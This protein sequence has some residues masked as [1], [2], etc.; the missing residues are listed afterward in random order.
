MYLHSLQHLTLLLYPLS[1]KISRIYFL[2]QLRPWG[3]PHRR[4]GR[5]RR[6]G[7]QT[8]RRA[9]VSPA[10]SPSVRTDARE[11]E[12]IR[13]SSRSYRATN[14]IGR[15]PSALERCLQSEFH[16]VL[17]AWRSPGALFDAPHNN[18]ARRLLPTALSFF[19]RT[20]YNWFDT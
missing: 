7:S 4:R 17:H 3:E 13:S 16:A 14:D 11:K 12:S 19:C 10:R 6:I 2:L 8:A 5:V 20:Q 1:L 15:A 9:R 18:V